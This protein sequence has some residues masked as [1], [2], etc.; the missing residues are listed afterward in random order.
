MAISQAKDGELEKTAKLKLGEFMGSLKKSV[1]HDHHVSLA[2][3][4]YSHL[5]ISADRNATS[6]TDLYKN[7]PIPGE[8]LIYDVINFTVNRNVGDEETY[9]GKIAQ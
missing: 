5:F 1:L 3:S 9:T 4:P 7:Y 8:A 2:I 6:V